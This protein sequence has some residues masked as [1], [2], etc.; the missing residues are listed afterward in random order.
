MN[1]EDARA[2]EEDAG[3]GGWVVA[4]LRDGGGQNS[5]GV[6]I[7]ISPAFPTTIN[8][9]PTRPTSPLTRQSATQRKGEKKKGERGVKYSEGDGFEE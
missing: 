9:F 7:D 3:R 6:V 1:K 2:A 8:T 4:P 5:D